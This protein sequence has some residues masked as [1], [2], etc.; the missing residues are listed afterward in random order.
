MEEHGDSSMIIEKVVGW[1]MSLAAWLLVTASAKNQ[2]KSS[3]QRIRKPFFQK[4]IRKSL[5]LQIH[6]AT[7][8][9]ATT[10]KKVSDFG[11]RFCGE[12][13]TNQNL[14]KTR[15]QN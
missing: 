3:K 1:L 10:V 2:R 4:L 7:Q 15:T 8:S 5:E 14:K 11:I 13:S 12:F 9:V 6:S